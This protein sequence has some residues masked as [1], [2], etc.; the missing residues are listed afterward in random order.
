MGLEVEVGVLA[1]L[2]EYDEE[3]ADWLKDALALVNQLL[4]AEGSATF[5]EPTRLGPLPNRTGLG[6]LSYRELHF[7]R[8]AYSFG[9]EHP[10]EAMPALAPD[11]NPAQDP[12]LNRYVG[13]FFCH[14]VNHSDSEGF[15]VPV[16]FGEILFD[17]R[18]PGAI[19]GS[20]Y[21]LRDELIVAAGPLGITLVDNV[22]SDSEADRIN[23]ANEHYVTAG[24]QMSWLAHWEA[25]RLSIEHSSAIV[26]M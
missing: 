21:R 26:Y 17:D 6:S 20:S 2:L 1:D 24:P 11:A 8:R 3:G 13:D 19:V 5:V 15:F 14:L 12:V 22:L 7:V 25:A 23:Q 9:K 10:G 4:A 18:L 16:D